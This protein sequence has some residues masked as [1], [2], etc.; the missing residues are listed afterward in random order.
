MYSITVPISRSIM[1][2]NV[3]SYKRIANIDTPSSVQD[4]I[5]NGCMNL[6][7]TYAHI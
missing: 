7:D 1:K 6:S 5:H 4:I 3:I 2:R